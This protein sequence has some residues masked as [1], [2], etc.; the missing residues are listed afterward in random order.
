MC[1]KMCAANLLYSILLKAFLTFT[2]T[3]CLFLLQLLVLYELENILNG[4]KLFVLL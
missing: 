4:Q 1:I 3:S 2:S